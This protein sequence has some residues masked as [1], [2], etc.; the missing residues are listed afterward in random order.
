[1][2]VGAGILA[3]AGE[4]LGAVVVEVVRL[5]EASGG[6]NS[7]PRDGEGSCVEV[8]CKPITFQKIY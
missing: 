5:T 2:G 1:M 7:V 3:A 6:K 8:E 4:A